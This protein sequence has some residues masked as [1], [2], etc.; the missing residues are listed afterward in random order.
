MADGNRT[1]SELVDFMINVG[2]DKA[3]R[4]NYK[5]AMLGI[6]AGAFI[7]LGGAAN[8]ISGSTLVK[9]DPGLAKTVGA[10]VFP[11]G[12]IMVVF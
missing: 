5:L 10:C 8:I 2:I 11:V 3:K 9:T 7:A 12:L 4:S 1:P 6:L